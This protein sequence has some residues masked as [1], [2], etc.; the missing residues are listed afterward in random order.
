MGD[1]VLYS[2]PLSLFTGK[3]RIALDE[4]GLAYELVSVPFSRAGYEP[5]HP[6][7]V[8]LNPK[9]QVPVLVDGDL[10]IYD[11]TIIFEYLEE[12]HPEPALYPRDPAR[13]ARCR[14]LEAAADEIFFPSIWELIR[15]VF[16]KPDGAGRDETAVANAKQAIAMHYD[17]LERHLGEQPYLCGADVTVADIGYFMFI[18]SATSLGRGL[19]EAHQGLQAWYGRVLARPAFT[20]ELERLM[21]ANRALTS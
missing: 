18:T 12:R 13:K 19:G 20:R 5:K 3:V 2:G 10:A 7:V 16:Y 1:V 14:V 11:S 8:E 9:Q 21:A 6:K 17:R 4:K 15:E